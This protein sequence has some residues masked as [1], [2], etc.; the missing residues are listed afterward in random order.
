MLGVEV[1]GELGFQRLDLTGLVIGFAQESLNGERVLVFL[2]LYLLILADLH[3]C[4]L[5]LQLLDL[6]LI[7]L[8]LP[9]D[10]GVGLNPLISTL[11]GI[12][13]LFDDLLRAGLGILELQKRKPI[14]VAHELG[15]LVDLPCKLLVT[16]DFH[17]RELRK[18]FSHGFLVLGSGL[19]DFLQGE[20]FVFLHRVA[21]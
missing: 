16:A 2:A 18:D 7:L 12:L 8:V 1:L 21:D 10:P 13:K 14:A 19:D 11:Y 9:N 3:L 6:V 17:G 20:V 4:H 5:M 15:L